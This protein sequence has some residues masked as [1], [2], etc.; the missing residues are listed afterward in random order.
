MSR[1][2]YLDS[3]DCVNANEP[4]RAQWSIPSLELSDL[5]QYKIRVESFTL[6]NVV[7]PVNR[8]YNKMTFEE[9]DGK[10]TDTYTITLT[11]QDYTGSQLATEIAS[12]MTTAST[13]SLGFTY[14]GSYNSQTKKIT[15]T[16]TDGLPN[17]FRFTTPTLS[18][19]AYRIAGFTSAGIT[20]QILAVTQTSNS[21]I[22]LAG[23]KYL[24]IISRSLSTGN[25]SSSGTSSVLVRIPVSA[26]FGSVLFYQNDNPEA[27]TL[28][29]D[30]LENVDIQVRDDEGNPY[31]LDSNHHVSL[32]I[33]FTLRQ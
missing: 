2:L 32:V 24:D 20:G 17:T 18:N 10:A 19:N 21:V 12:Q 3:R 15:I 5:V 9:D 22:D 33:Q 16:L 23:T 1:T 7:Y 31:E 13:A 14:S 27:L 28:R 4:H 29:N 6:N 11:N 25:V 8:F 26:D 30:N